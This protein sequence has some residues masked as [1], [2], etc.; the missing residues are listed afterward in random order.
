MQ[1]NPSDFWREEFHVRSLHLLIGTVACAVGVFV[2]A[3]ADAQEQPTTRPSGANLALVATAS[4]SF[5]SGDTSLAALNDGNQPRSSRF[6]RGGTYGNWPQ[7]NTQWVQYEWSQPISTNA[8]DV[9]WWA[10]GQGVNL[11]KAA[12]LKYWD[13]K[14]FAAVPGADVGVKGNQF[15]T[16]RFDEIQTSKLRLEMDSA[17]TFSTGILEWKVYDSGKSP[18]FPPMLKAG[19]DRVVVLGG[20]TFL[21]G[22]VKSLQSDASDA[23]VSWSKESGPGDVNFENASS[24]T[25]TARFS[26]PGQYVLKLS[27]KEGDLSSSSTLNVT[28]QPAAPAASLQPFYATR[29][30]ISS[31]LWS[32]RLKALIVN[33]IPHCIDKI[34]DPNLREGGISNFIEAGNKLAGR[35]FKPHVG[36]P[37][38]N[39]WVY[40]TIEAMAGRCST[41]IRARAASMK[42]I[43][44]G[45]SSRRRSRIIT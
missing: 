22:T 43:R 15:N 25:T 28:V 36:Y 1:R 33:W 37:F 8:T 32:A 3:I 4:S 42:D 45:I 31:P 40:N 27:A 23:T 9:Y 38:S 18:K 35:P 39:A 5:T 10:D 14:E 41:G 7:R 30:K 2:S 21:N 29:Y 44:P 17:G 6:S 12:R 13:G 34:S 19:I 16:A 11:P 20:K 26:S 24:P